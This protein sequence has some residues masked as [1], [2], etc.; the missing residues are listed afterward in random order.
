M[1]D[2]FP[3]PAAAVRRPHFIPPL[4]NFWYFALHGPELKVGKM[5]P[6]TLLGESVLLG[7][8]T[9]GKVFAMRN[10]C[11]HRS[12]PLHHGQFDG[13]DVQ[14]LYH[15]W[16][17]GAD[18]RCSLIPTLC[19]D[20]AHFGDRI[21]NKTYP[22]RESQGIIWVFVGEMDEATM[23]EPPCLPDIGDSKP[24]IYFG[25][26][27]P[28]NAE[29]TAYTFFDPSHVAFVHSS[30]FVHRKSHNIR[31]KVK[32]FEPAP[33]GWTMK[34]HAAPKENMFYRLF[35]KNATTEIV[36]S[37]PGT[38]IE[39]IRG[40]KH[41]AISLA[42]ITPISDEETIMQQTM[43]WSFPWMGPAKGL[44]R[45]LIKHFLTED[46]HYGFMQR[47]GLA[48]NQPFMLIGDADV[49]IQWFQRLRQ[50]WLQSD[51]GNLPF[52]NPISPQT[53]RFKS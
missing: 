23:P 39:S 38:R 14:C 2:D 6:I 27:Y 18:G 31:E 30:P 10:L 33:L 25:I 4:R 22:C 40:D 1:S 41:W 49:Q 37:L 19:G 3:I 44:I 47:P 20:Q 53:L 21:R 16:K 26:P 28:L 42:T 15:G 48:A 43:Y 36:Y 29:H 52:V 50:A 13:K 5:K 34:R 45:Y 24:E 7:R 35:G 17:F 51:N 46:R 11:P 32:E 12:T 8:T 9:E